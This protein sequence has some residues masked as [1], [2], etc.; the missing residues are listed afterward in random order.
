MT[1]S[2]IN[3]YTERGFTIVELLIVIVVIAI[4]AGITIVAYSGI[5]NRAQQSKVQQTA[6]NVQGVAEAFNA[7]KGYYPALAVTGTDALALGST[8]TKI[9]TGITIVADLATSPITSAST[10]STGNL[11]V[12]YAC[13]PAVSGACGTQAGGNAPTGGRITYW[14]PVLPGKAYIYLGKATSSSVFGF[15][16]S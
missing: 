7:D 11:T 6:S 16:A 1:I 8:S 10:P 15:P 5:T 2:K 4:L 3:S 9:P 13:F 14:D 12:A